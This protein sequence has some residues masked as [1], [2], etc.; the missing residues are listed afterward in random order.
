MLWAVVLLALA[1]GARGE[2]AAQPNADGG[3]GGSPYVAGELLVLYEPGTSAQ[4]ERAV[5]RGSG[6]RTLEDFSGKVRLVSFPGIRREESG[7][8]RARDLKRELKDLPGKVRLVSFPGIRREESGKARARALKRE[9]ETLRNQPRVEAADY[10]YIREASFVPN[11]PKFGDP[12]QWGLKKAA[13]PRAWDRARGRG[14]KIAIVDS[15]VYQN[16]PDIGKIVA[17]KDFVSGDA[18]ANDPYGHGTHVAGIAAALTDNGR[19]MAG[20]CPACKLLIARVMD[21]RGD[22]TDSDVVAAINWSVNNGA[23]VV[24]LSLGAP[25][26]SSVLEETINKAYANGNGAVVVAAAGNEGTNTKQY[27]AAYR[28][29]IAVSATNENDRIARFS[30]RGGW[31]DLAAPGTGILST[32]TGGGYDLESGTSEST[33]FVSALAGLLASRGKTA[34]EI[35]KR[36]QSTATDLGPAGDD[37]Y[38]GHGRINAGQPV[39]ITA[40]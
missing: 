29:V 15:G 28:K 13:F 35:R 34:A 38:Y 5:V 10:N 27:P 17:Q 7:K 3:N 39:S 4:T 30:S 22:A 14:A 31:V 21:S 9:L 24:N 40:I 16:H 23:D 37:P 1:P 19:G 32:R 6:G 33:P 36:M 11:D 18:V 25:Q 8:T 20:G 12:G 2:A 26:K